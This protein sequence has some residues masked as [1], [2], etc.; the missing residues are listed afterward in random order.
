MPEQV[1]MGR[2]TKAIA[3]ST[4]SRGLSDSK[5]NSPLYLMGIS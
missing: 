3:P 4:A 1:H 2:F 5:Q